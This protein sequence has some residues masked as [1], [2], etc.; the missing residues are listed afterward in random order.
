[1]KLGLAGRSGCI[2]AVAGAL[3]VRVREDKLSAVTSSNRAEQ[4]TANQ[5]RSI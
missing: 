5:M 1:M 2:S 4:I 3:S